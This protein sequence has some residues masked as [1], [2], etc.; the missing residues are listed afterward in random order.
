MSLFNKKGPILLSE[1][2]KDI[3]RI[4]A[5]NEWKI[6]LTY[7]DRFNLYVIKLVDS[8][9]IITDKI[10]I[11]HPSKISPTYLI[12]AK[13]LERN[14]YIDDYRE[15][16][17]F[18]PEY[19]SFFINKK[20]LVNSEKVEHYLVSGQGASRCIETAFSKAL[21]EILER[22]VS[23]VGDTS[24]HFLKMSEKEISKKYK[25]FHPHKYHK[26][27]NAQVN[28]YLHGDSSYGSEKVIQWVKGFNLINNEKTY[29]PKQVTSWIY[30]DT[31][32][33]D[34]WCSSTTNGVA[35]FF[36]K[37]GA[38]LRGLLEVIE[39]DAFFVHWLTKTP[40]VKVELKDL[41][42]NIKDVI[43]GFKMRRLSVYITNITSIQIPTVCI[44]V[45][46]EKKELFITTAGAVKFVD[47]VESAL[48]EMSKITSSHFSKRGIKKSKCKVFKNYKP[49]LFELNRIEIQEYW[50]MSGVSD[51]LSWFLSGKEISFENAC[52]GDLFTEE[53]NQVSDKEKLSRC[54]Q[55]LERTGEEY[56]P[57]VYYPKNKIQEKLGFYIAQVYIPKAFPLFFKEKYAP[58][59]SE[60]LADFAAS[61]NIESFDL[62]FYP[63]PLR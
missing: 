5:L 63:H 8:V 44:V 47:A 24:S 30:G 46:S 29:I 53:S 21:G 39:R 9:F 15:W 23:G 19:K 36:S 43:D 50:Q 59:H 13:Y 45:I 61:K 28:K 26:L 12:I 16:S 3:E 60:R 51:E 55:I 37:E 42:P 1:Y 2:I 54:L 6:P 52:M 48:E 31:G 27:M 35:G 14:G 11:Q 18:V 17:T 34:I 58:F 40:P 20:I 10:T 49:F 38:T 57:I 56:F 25:Y 33:K 7:I 41:P 22:V 32:I 4:E 62:N